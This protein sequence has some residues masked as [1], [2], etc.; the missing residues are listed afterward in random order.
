MTYAF[1]QKLAEGIILFDGAM[2]SMLYKKGA[3]INQCYEGLN[4]SAPKMVSDIHAEYVKAG[5]DVLETNTFGA[6][7]Y[8]LKGFGLEAQVEEINQAAVKLARAATTGSKVLVAGAVG[9]LG[10]YLK[11]LGPI[12]P[13]EAQAWY[14]QQLQALVDAGA[15]VIVLESFTDMKELQLAVAVLR[16]FSPVPLVAQATFNEKNETAIG[17]TVDTFICETDK[18]DVDALGFNCS[19]GPADM[20]TLLEKAVRLSAKPISC[21]PNAGMPKIVDGRYFYLASSEYMAEYAKRFIQAGAR[22]VGGCCGTAPKHT[23]AMRSSIRALFPGRHSAHRETPGGVCQHTVAEM[24]TEKKS[25]LGEKLASGRFVTSVEITPPRSADPLGTIE[26]C[27]YLQ[28]HGIDAVNIP[29]GPRA[30]ARLSPMV[31]AMLIEKQ[32]GI[33][34]VLH[35]TCR[36]RN[37]IGM[38]SDLLGLHAA[39]IRNLLIITGD[40]PKMGDYP[41]AT[42]VFDVDSIGLTRI[43]T[44]LNQGQDVGGNPIPAPLSFV[45]GVGVNPGAINL[46]EEIKRLHQKIDAGAEFMITQ[47]VF[48][49]E[50]FLRFQDRIKK[51]GIPVIAGVWPLVS[52]K[53]A[54]FMNNEVPGASVPAA[55]MERM[56]AKGSGSEAQQEGVA[57]AG[58]AL[59]KI[60]SAI[61]GVQVSAAFGK[62]ELAVEVLRQGGVLTGGEE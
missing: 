57:I 56:R 36:D 50:I 7:G 10:A 25:R 46:D 51:L 23:K 3:Y 43:V 34:T 16:D 38:Q 32:V 9:P 52:Y 55:I 29:D 13:E 26:K 12:A 62:V 40:P 48:D 2:G 59:R 15:D 53:N 14:R 24:A 20:M 8:K 19:T 58:E 17:T 28:K 5:C 27:M 11:P 22:I 31:L 47:P 21:Q 49:P 33:E 61:Q 18:L 6:N 4:L 45:K 60:R 44:R 1:R 41:E 39:G 37:I 54:E 35:Y 42:A 30:S